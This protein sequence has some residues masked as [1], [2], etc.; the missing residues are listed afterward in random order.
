MFGGPYHGAVRTFELLMALACMAELMPYVP[1]KVPGIPMARI[2]E[3]RTM[4]K[5]VRFY[6]GRRLFAYGPNA[7]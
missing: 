3:N 6:L 5:I 4:L 2:S 1:S 7:P